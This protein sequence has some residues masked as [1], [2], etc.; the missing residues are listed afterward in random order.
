VRFIHH[1]LILTAALALAACASD[2]ATFVRQNGTLPEPKMLEAD[3]HDCRKVGKSTAGVFDNALAGAGQ[4]F[5]DGAHSSNNP[6][7][8]IATAGAGAVFGLFIGAVNEGPGDNYNLCM[9]RKGYQLAGA[10]QAEAA[11]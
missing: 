3:A 9:A 2:D 4:G 7:A 11:E 8:A 10:Q 1:P 5:Y 6:L